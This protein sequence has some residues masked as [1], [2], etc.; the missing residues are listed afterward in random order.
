MR[1]YD[2]FEWNNMMCCRMLISRAYNMDGA[3]GCNSL[4]L[5]AV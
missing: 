5:E 1:V 4:R 2:A 3:V